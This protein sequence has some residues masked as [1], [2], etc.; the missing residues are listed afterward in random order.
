MNAKRLLVAALF[1]LAITL[2]APAAGDTTASAAGTTA[3]ADWLLLSSN[4]YGKMRTYSVAA[5]GSRLTPLFPPRGRLDPVAVSRDGSTVAYS[6]DEEKLAA[7]YVSRA[8]GTGLRRVAKRGQ[9]PAFSPDGKLLAFV[10]RKGIWVVG[11]DGRGLR[12]LAAGDDPTFD[13]SPSG[14][15]LVFMRVIDEQKQRFALVVQPL[16]GKPRVLVRTGP[17]DEA[18]AEEYQPDWSPDGRWIA[19][20][21]REDKQRRNGLTLIR[22]NGKSRHRIVLGAGEEDTYEWS[23]DGHWVAYEDV[24]ELDYIRTDGNWHKIASHWAGSLAWSPDRKRLAFS[25]FVGSGADLS[26]D[27][28]VASGEGRGPKRLHLGLGL[29]VWQDLFWSPDSS[30]LALAGSAGRDPVQLWVVGQDGSG[31]RRLTNDGANFP[32]GWTGLAPVL[33]PAPPL[34]PTEHVLGADSVATSTPVAALSADG[35]RVAFAPRP[36]VTDCEH[37]VVWTPGAE[38]T[39]LGNLPAPCG[40]GSPAA[41]V[42]TLA[43]AGT[44]A[45]WVSGGANESGENCWFTLMSATLADPVG[46]VV[47]GTG[48]DPAEGDVC[49]STDIDHLRGDGDLLVFNDQP[50][51]ETSLLRIGVGAQKCGDLL[52]TTL[53]KG[54][55][56]APAASVSAGLIATRKPGAVAVLDEHGALVRFFSFAPADVNEAVLDAGRLVVWRFGVL[57]VYDVANGTRVVSQPLPPGY[58]LEDVDGGI[59]VLLRG[60]TIMLLRLADGHSFTLTPGPKTLTDLEPPGL[61]YSYRTADGGGRVVF[62]ARSE[63]EQRF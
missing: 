57:E 38:L 61:Y 62:L 21:N 24:P 3:D 22:P 20:V 39:R 30:R 46:R 31:L 10:G 40:W 1:T 14:K 5:D 19:Y 45:A 25:V 51:H 9:Y 59:A 49:K 12:Q 32:L 54:A 34:P 23:P 35:P 41:A 42:S 56:A 33:P 11:T 43:L 36:T 37:V 29:S 8:D 28:N 55:Q 2:T 60:E 13:W 63:L 50:R 53:R 18:S 15:A 4:R 17:N 7:I 48:P 26:I 58:R 27:L 52:C 44:R 47:G 16:R 6:A